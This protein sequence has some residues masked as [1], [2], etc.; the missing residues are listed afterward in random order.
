MVRDNRRDYTLNKLEKTQNLEIAQISIINLTDTVIPPNVFDS[1]K[2]GLNN[3][4]GS[5]T[6]PLNLLSKFDGLFEHW[7]V[8]A[9]TENLSELDILNVRAR[10]FV[11]YNEMTKCSTNTAY[12]KN[13]TKFL[14]QNDLLLVPV[15]KS[16]NLCLMTKQNYEEK[17]KNVF[18][19]TNKFRPTD[20][21]SISK[22]PINIRALIKKLEP[23]VSKN[24]YYKML[25]L[26]APKQSYG[27]VKCHKPNLPLRPIVSTVDSACNGAEKYIQRIIK[28]LENLC[29]FSINSTKQ[30]KNHFLETRDSFDTSVHE[31]VSIDAQKLYTSVNIELVIDEMIK[32]IY[33]SPTEF[34]KIDPNEKTNLGLSTKIPLKEIFRTFLY[35]I[36]IKFNCFSTVAGCYQQ[37]DGLSMGSKISPLIANFYLNIM[38]Q[39]IIK[40]E[41]EKG[42]ISAYCRFVDDVYCII[43]KDQKNRILHSINNFDPKFIKF[44]NEVMENNSLPFLDTEIYLDEQNVPQIKKFRKNTASDVIMNFKSVCPKKYKIATLKGDVF[45]CHYTCSTE[46]NLNNALND[47]AEIY[48]KNEYPKRLVDNTIREIRNKNFENNGNKTNYQELKANA[49]NQF[50][51]LCIPFTAT[52]CEKV[53]SKLIRLLKINTPN[54]H[55]NIAWKLQKI[56]KVFSHRLKMP[57]PDLEK[58]GVTYKFDCLC[59]ESYIGESKRQLQNRIKEHNQKSKQTAIS[60]HIYGSVIK[61]IQPCSEFTVEISNQFGG[62]P[63]PNQKFSFIKNRFTILQNNLTNM[64]DRRTFEAV[65]ITVHKPKLNAQVLHRKVSII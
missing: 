59:Q 60:N 36:L 55:I 51:T 9:R 13:V 41:I 39:K 24:D 4:I 35:Q 50:Y 19:D 47:L 33:K 54:Y 11:I 17:I 10:C 45:R 52:R 25:P 56:R 16:K 7:S 43:R 37:I 18:S 63:N 5:K 20:H 49:P 26:E 27:T 48:A 14:N 12:T 1:L 42:N 44:T 40:T 65:A 15:D 62:Q 22:H 31:I 34:F 3:S 2:F 28:P 53:A 46:E 61:N 32:E 30:F 23:Y 29:T 6:K 8:Y 64:R 38:E 58:I 21:E 57:V